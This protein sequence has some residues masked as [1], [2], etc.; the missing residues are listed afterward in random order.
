MSRR[1]HGAVAVLGMLVLLALAVPQ[2][3]LAQYDSASPFGIGFQSA[4]PSYGISGLYDVNEQITVQAIIGALGT[5]TNFGGRGIYRFQI[6]PKY[7]LY[8][9]GTVGLWRYDYTIDTE[10]VV[11]FGGGAGVEL[12]WR[13]ILEDDSFPPL[14]TS[15]DLSFVLANFEYYNFSGISTGGGVHYRF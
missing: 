12:D 9:F 4:W 7:N 3:A 2:R 15:L 14:Y 8:G 13:R 11:G 5:V 1:N 6:E 10:S